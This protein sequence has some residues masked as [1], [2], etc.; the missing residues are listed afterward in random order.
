[1]AAVT[2][3][4][5]EFRVNDVD[6]ESC[7][8]RQQIYLG[9]DLCDRFK[10]DPKAVQRWVSYMNSLP[11][12]SDADKFT[13]AAKRE[14]DKDYETV[15]VGMTVQ[16]FLRCGGSIGEPIKRIRHADGES[17]VYRHLNMHLVV[18]RKTGVI[19]NIAY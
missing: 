17:V 14:C 15:R 12:D 2:T 4:S 1:M 3:A 19:T 11:G 8:Y 10:R 9:Q 7:H 5:G 6:V 13:E 16:R 18:D